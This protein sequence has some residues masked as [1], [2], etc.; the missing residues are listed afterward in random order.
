MTEA[1]LL[2][3]LPKSNKGN[4]KPKGTAL[5]SNFLRLCFGI[6][7]AYARSHSLHSRST[8]KPQAPRALK[9]D[10]RSSRK[11]Q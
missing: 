1:T 5:V 8:D 6:E 4:D 7:V 9:T 11:Q 10:V 2:P 3:R